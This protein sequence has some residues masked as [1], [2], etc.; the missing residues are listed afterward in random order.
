MENGEVVERPSHVG[1]VAAGAA[2]R[3][4]AADGQRLDVLAFRLLVAVEIFMEIGEVVQRIRHVG[5]VAAGGWSPPGGGGWT[6]P[7][8]TRPPPRQGG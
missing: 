8:R 5:V 1:V 6:A 3:K 4:A 7:R 2:L